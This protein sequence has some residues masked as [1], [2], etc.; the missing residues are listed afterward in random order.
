MRPNII[1]DF[2]IPFIK[3]V[4]DDVADVRYSDGCDIRNKDVRNA[5]A[6]IIRTR[7]RCNENLLKNSSVKY[8]ATATIGFDHIDTHYCQQHNIAWT[9]APGCNAKSV[10]QYVATALS[11]LHQKSKINLNTAVV[12]I[13][14]VG[15]VGK[16]I[17]EFCEAIGVKTLLNDPP[18]QRTE[19]TGKFVLLEEIA[20]KCDIITFHTPLNLEGADKTFHL[21][22]DNFF[23]TLQKMPVIINTA[24]GEICDTEALKKAKREQLIS[25][26]VLDCWEKE[27][28]I[29]TDLLAMCDIA[30]PHIAG[31]S[32]DGKANATTACVQYISKCFNLEMDNW[33]VKD[34]PTPAQSI[35]TLDNISANFVDVIAE[36]VLKTYQIEKESSALKNN[37]HNFEFFRNHYPLRREFDFYTILL[38]EKDEEIS[39]ILKR[40]GFN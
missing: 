22:D 14:G 35:L 6:L 1:I 15:H 20:E 7:T 18:R 29:D 38:K 12:G 32:A 33:Q 4:F 10:Q 3:G 27:P 39:G 26:I 9:N 21:V 37:I 16:L 8:I 24:R 13:V 2:N 5:D 25:G 28:N 36:A 40:V 17:A 34:I 23:R 11:F 30:T 31:Y 19:K